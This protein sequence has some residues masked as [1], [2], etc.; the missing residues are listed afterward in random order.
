M[1]ATC[2]ISSDLR[3]A[4]GLIGLFI[5]M[6]AG[7]TPSAEHQSVPEDV[8]KSPPVTVQ[9]AEA[10]LATLHPTIDLVGTLVAIPEKTAVIS[11][12]SGGWVSKLDVVEG[13][14]VKAGEV[15]VELDARSA[16]V[17]VARAK[18]VVAEKTASLE[19]LEHGYLPGEIAAARKDVENA[20]AKVDGLKNELAAL[21]DLLDRNEISSV[22]YATKAKA[23]ESAEASLKAT[24]EREKLIEAGN[25]PEAI[26]EAQAL[27]DAAKADLQQA[28]LALRWC[29]ITSPIDGILVQ[30]L[31]RQGQFFDKAVPVARVTDLSRVFVQLSIPNRDFAKVRP[32][33][34]V[35]VELD[36]LPGKTF[37]GR[38]ERIS[39][40]ADPLT[41]NVAAF[42]AVENDELLLRPGLSCCARVSLPTIDDALV[43]PVAAIA[44]NSGSPVVTVIRD[45]RAYETRVSI[46]VQTRE[47]VQITEGLSPG[48]IV[49]TSGGTGLPSGCPIKVGSSVKAT[50]SGA[51]D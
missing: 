50:Y 25:R 8:P 9:T 14:T 23:V 42:A 6:V 44:D 24:Q 20:A 38:I 17:A 41:G 37:P 43:V 5:A 48:E 39:G 13:Q 27:L 51:V 32:G 45:G 49:A 21:K 12:Q 26:A 30:L 46:G 29:S 19:L 36:S 3:Q 4:M 47:Q 7:C 28:E 35:V 33:S 11:P 1:P 10:R 16:Q 40:E 15:L 34:Q 22:V 18:A 2:L 31:A